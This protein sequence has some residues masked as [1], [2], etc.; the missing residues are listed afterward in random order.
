MSKLMIALFVTAGIGLAGCATPRAEPVAAAKPMNP[1]APMSKDAYDVAIKNADAQ[2]KMDKDACSSRTGNAKDICLADANGKDKVAKADAEAGYK[3]TP[4][5]RED[6]RGTRAEAT[7]NVSK[8]KCDDL[9]GNA[10]DVCVKEA[11]AVLVKAKADA[12][13][14]R[15]SADTR[16]DA[17][18]KQADARKDADAAKRNADYKVAVEKCDALAGTAKV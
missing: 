17:A 11:D 6:A 7:Y 16:Q 8:E 5:A 18:A 12:K 9:S 14:D 1:V 2:Y 4:K 13:V 3:N 15:V 10:K